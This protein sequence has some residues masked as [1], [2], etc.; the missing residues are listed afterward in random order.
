[1]GSRSLGLLLVGIGV[2]AVVVG[3]LVWAGWLSWF[4]RLPGDVRI[5]RDNLRVYF[6]IVSMILI[7]LLLTLILNLLRRF[8]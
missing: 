7:S 2:A 1:M 6:P 4:G 5:E 3:L 8:F